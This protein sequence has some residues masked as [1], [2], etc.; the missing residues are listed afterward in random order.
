MSLNFIIAFMIW[1]VDHTHRRSIPRAWHEVSCPDAQPCQGQLY[2]HFLLHLF[3]S[4]AIDS[5]SCLSNFWVA[6][7]CWS[8]SQLS[9]SERCYFAVVFSN[10]NAVF[11]SEYR[12]VCNSTDVSSATWP[13]QS[14]ARSSHLQSLRRL[15]DRKASW[16]LWVMAKS[17]MGSFLESLCHIKGLCRY[18]CCY[19]TLANGLRFCR[20]SLNAQFTTYTCTIYSLCLMQL[21]SLKHIRQCNSL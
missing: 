7:I 18:D 14:P 6:V 13:S 15:A 12:A 16:Q 3:C 9:S 1:A 5:L 11:L 17:L 21:F 10:N 19:V 2:Y 4:P 20:C 8:L